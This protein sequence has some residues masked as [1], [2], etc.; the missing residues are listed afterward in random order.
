MSNET[1]Q[2]MGPVKSEVSLL[3]T[4]MHYGIGFNTYSWTRLSSLSRGTLETLWALQVQ[5]TKQSVM[6]LLIY[7]NNSSLNISTLAV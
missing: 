7:G 5:M 2:H 1:L 4:Q 3:G 6:D